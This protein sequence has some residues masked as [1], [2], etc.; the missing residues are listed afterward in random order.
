MKQK[1]LCFLHRRHL[2]IV[3]AVLVICSMTTAFAAASVPEISESSSPGAVANT[4]LAAKTK[5]EL[6]PADV[7]MVNDGDKRQIIKVYRLMPDESPADIPRD[8]F[9]RDGWSYTLTDITK[10]NRSDTRIHTESVEIDTDNKD[11]DTVLSQLP[12]AMEYQENGYSGLLSLDLESVKCE[13]SGR[14]S[15][16]YNVSAVREYLH[17]STNDLALI[18]KTITDNG[19]TLTLADVSWQAQD[20]VNVDYSD[21]PG[22]YCAVAKYTATA[23]KSVVTGYI[24]TAVYTGEVTKAATDG[25]VYTAYFSGRADKASS[26]DAPQLGRGAV[27]PLIAGILAVAVIAGIAVFFLLRPNVKV[28]KISEDSRIMVAKAR[29]SAKN[30]VV[31]LSP[32]YDHEGEG[33]FYLEIDKM[34]AKKLNSKFIEAIYGSCKLK[35]QIAFEG[36]VYKIEMDF[37]TKTIT[38]IY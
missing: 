36:N 16:S 27:L 24:T 4:S 33:R 23:S 31:D 8:S 9:V 5:N 11:L 19:R 17:L 26:T 25:A 30:P 13:E 29:I 20:Y 35:H 6:Y 2:F 28:Y 18:P 3:M 7:Q 32:L 14:K 34:T 22:S 38:A 21:I 10:T 12:S 1:L 15:S 37:K